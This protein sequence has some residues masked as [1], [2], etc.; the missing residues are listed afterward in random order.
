[1][2]RAGRV[3]DGQATR[4][5]DDLLRAT[6]LGLATSDPLAVQDPLTVEVA[7]GT[8]ARAAVSWVRSARLNRNAGET[9][10]TGIPAGTTIAF[11]TGWTAATN[12]EFVFAFP[13]TLALPAGGG[14]VL[15][16][17][18]VYVGVDQ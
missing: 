18:A 13:Y 11:I 14:F 12:G 2:A 17:N 4:W 10:W 3:S 16:A 9:S 7:G 5:L 8:Y 15:P 1:M 6:H